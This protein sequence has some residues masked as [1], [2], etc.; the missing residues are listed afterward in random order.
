[1]KFYG[2]ADYK[3]E[4]DTG[5]AFREKM[6]DAIADYDYKNFGEWVHNNIDKTQFISKEEA[7]ELFTVKNKITQKNKDESKRLE[8]VFNTLAN[9]FGYE[10]FLE[11][12]KKEI[13]DVAFAMQYLKD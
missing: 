9:K 1:M 5:I 2:S 7:V 12:A 3:L 10:P 6:G 13:F 8:N 4:I 11:F